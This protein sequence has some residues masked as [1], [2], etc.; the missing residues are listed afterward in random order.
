MSIT[1]GITFKS[2]IFEDEQSHSQ[3]GTDVTALANG[4]GRPQ[5]FRV[6]GTKT[7]AGFECAELMA[8]PSGDFIFSTLQGGTGV[9]RGFA[10][11]PG[12][13][14]GGDKSVSFVASG[15]GRLRFG[16][17][18]NP[19]VVVIS[20]FQGEG[21]W[22]FTTADPG[23]SLNWTLAHNERLIFYSKTEITAIGNGITT[24]ATTL[25]I[26]TNA[27]LLAAQS[28]VI[29]QPGG[30][31]SY[32]LTGTASAIQFSTSAA[33][34]TVAGTSDVG[35]KN[36]PFY[37]GQ[38]NE[39]LTYTFNAATTDALGQIRTTLFYLGFLAASL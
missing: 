19:N 37:D 18:G 29:T 4:G 34:S 39:T 17:G 9:A 20:A 1:R 25:T 8:Q 38:T 11:S 7:A 31:T 33:L 13:F 15:A 32:K 23:T 16:S 14:A 3:A 36:C 27:I 28:R 6:Y 35:T 21:A 5:A 22:T 24:Q 26:P 12:A 10:F 30:T 2:V